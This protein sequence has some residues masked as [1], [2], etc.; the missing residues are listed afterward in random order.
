MGDGLILP[1]QRARRRPPPNVSCK[2][3]TAGGLGS[4]PPHW[5]GPALRREEESRWAWPLLATRPVVMLCTL[6][7]A[8]GEVPVEA[9]RVVATRGVADGQE[10]AGRRWR[11]STLGGGASH[12]CSGSGSR[13]WPPSSAPPSR[14]SAG[15]G[16]RWSQARAGQSWGAGPNFH[17]H[18][19]RA[20]L[21]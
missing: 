1:V 20:P 3:M 16:R 10:W 18:V 19:T 5:L 9:K 2:S 14:C 11:R 8:W 15:S 12:G 7:C 21:G 4:T 13:P 6:L 17:S